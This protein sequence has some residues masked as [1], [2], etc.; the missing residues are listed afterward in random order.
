MLYPVG[1]LLLVLSLVDDMV[2]MMTVRC[3]CC[4]YHYDVKC[5]EKRGALLVRSPSMENQGL[6][7]NT[8]EIFG[9]KKCI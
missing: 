8:G 2:M 7:K 6:P 3:Y 1:L 4:L 5:E 9:E